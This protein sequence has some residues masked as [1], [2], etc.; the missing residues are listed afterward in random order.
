MGLAM[1]TDQSS[2][3]KN[4]E[5]LSQAE[6][7]LLAMYR[8]SKGTANRIPFEEIVLQAWK[9]FP[10]QFSLNNHPEYPDSYPV[11]KRLYSDLI[12]GRLA[13]SVS[14]EVCR[15][16]YKGLELAKELDDRVS[17]IKIE[18]P[19]SLNREEEEFLKHALRSR[20]LITWKQSKENDLIDY[21]ARVFFQ[22]STGTPVRER[23]RKVEN[24]RD[25]IQKA[26]AI[27][28]TEAT[29]LNELFQFLITKFTAL[30][31]EG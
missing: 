4:A 19:S 7:V 17:N 31:E 2:K 5:V 22:F 15:L 24:A 1:K 18:Q 3:T 12:T 9:D 10:K 13:I 23:R 21:D 11:N 14:K 16:T 20:A 27:G 8:V 29:A 26:V 6:M 28:M 25:A 30:F